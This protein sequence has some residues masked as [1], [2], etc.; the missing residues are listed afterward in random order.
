[1]SW[2]DNLGMYSKIWNIMVLFGD[3]FEASY[4]DIV[5]FLQFP[6]QPP[7]IPTWKTS[8]GWMNISTVDIIWFM[9]WY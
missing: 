8:R 1:M 9:T 4:S 3:K 5:V 2:F 7:K 6:Q